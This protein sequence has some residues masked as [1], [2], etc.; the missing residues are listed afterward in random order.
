MAKETRLWV[1]DCTAAVLRESGKKMTFDELLE[2]INALP[3][4]R[5]PRAAA[6]AEVMAALDFLNKTTCE[7][8]QDSITVYSWVGEQE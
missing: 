5:R 2:A 3:D 4:F 6:G 7:V 1:V 8:V